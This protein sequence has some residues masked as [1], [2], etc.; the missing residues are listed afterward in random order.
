MI[1]NNQLVSV[2]YSIKFLKSLET[3]HLNHN[4]LQRIP[5]Q[6]GELSKIRDIDFS[7][8]NIHILPTSLLKLTRL[9]RIII[10]NNPIVLPNLSQ[11]ISWKKPIIFRYEIKIKNKKK[12]I[13]NKKNY[14]K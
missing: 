7:N 2:P 4:L 1:N 12:I 5:V 10:D 8:N 9:D 14:K 6:L 13:N 11:A 3:L